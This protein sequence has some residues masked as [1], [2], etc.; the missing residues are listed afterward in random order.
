MNS[1]GYKKNSR[2]KEKP[3]NKQAAREWEDI[4]CL[5]Q[6]K[7]ANWQWNRLLENLALVQYTS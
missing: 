2:N 1:Q 4:I 5:I 7:V 3:K 6:Q